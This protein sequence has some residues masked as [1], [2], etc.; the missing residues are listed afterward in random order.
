MGLLISAS[1]APHCGMMR[2]ATATERAWAIGRLMAEDSPN[3]VATASS[4]RSA[5]I[6]CI[7]PRFQSTGTSRD[8]HGAH[9][10][11]SGLMSKKGAHEVL[12][13]ENET[14]L[15]QDYLIKFR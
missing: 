3:V 14:T 15:R 7:W 13:I 12:G 10:R 4:L 1:A 8:V 6:S 11:F 9:T 5:I 2:R